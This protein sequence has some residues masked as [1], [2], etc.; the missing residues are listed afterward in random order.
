MRPNGTKGM[1]GMNE[2]WVYET[3]MVVLGSTS[4]FWTASI[5]SVLLMFFRDN[6][7]RCRVIIATRSGEEQGSSKQVET[8]HSH[9]YR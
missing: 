9:R 2:K 7:V 8:L 4:A 6:S 1:L 3:G 5:I